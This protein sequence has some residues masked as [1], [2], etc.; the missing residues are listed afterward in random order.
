MSLHLLSAAGEGYYQPV[1]R[2]RRQYGAALT[3][4]EAWAAL[5]AIGDATILTSEGCVTAFGG[6]QVLTVYTDIH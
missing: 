2:D 5:R 4:R 6:A 3:V 1:G